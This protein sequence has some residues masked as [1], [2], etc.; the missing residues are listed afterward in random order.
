MFGLY[1]RYKL[2]YTARSARKFWEE[3][4]DSPFFIEKYG[5]GEEE[6]TRRIDRRR[7]GR[8]GKKRVWLQ[9]LRDGSLDG[10]NFQMHFAPLRNGRPPKADETDDSTLHTIF[11]RSGDPVKIATDSLPID[12]C[13]NQ[14]L[15]MRIPPTL[16][17]KDIEKELGQCAG[18]QYL[19]VGEAHANKHYFAI[20]WAVFDTP[21]NTNDAKS[22]MLDSRVIQDN[23]LQLDV[24][25]RGAQVKFRTAPSGSGKI[26]RLARDYKQARD[27]VRFVEREDRE[28]LW[29]DGSAQE[30]AD[31]DALDTN[32]SA[33]IS[34]RVI[35]VMDLRPHFAPGEDEDEVLLQIADSAR[36]FSSYDEEEDVRRSIEKGLD[37]HLDLL[38]QVYNC[39][40]YSSTM[41]DFPEEL[42]RRARGHFRRCY[43]NGETEAEREGRDSGE[44][45]QNMGEEQWAENLD[46]KH[47]LLVGASSVDIE[48][49]GGVDIDKLCLELAIPFTRQD[50]KEKHRCI[51]EVPNVAA[52]GEAVDAATPPTKP[53]DKLFRALIFVQKHVCNKHKDLIERELG[54]ERRA[55][56]AYLNNYI[57]DPTR[58]MPPLTG[59]LGGGRGGAGAG[60]NGHAG[61]VAAVP[62]AF[63]GGDSTSFGGVLRLGA[64]TFAP[65]GAYEGGGGGRRRGGRRGGGGG[66]GDGYRSPSPSRNGGGRLSERLGG[67]TNNPP[68]IH[69]GA[70]LS[71]AGGASAASGGIAGPPLHLRLGGQNPYGLPSP[72]VRGGAGMTSPP[73][74]SMATSSLAA[75]DPLPP[76]PRPLD[77]RAARGQ[78]RSYQDLDTGG[79][80]GQ[81]DVMDLEY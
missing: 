65:E 31:R 56:I 7:R 70:V 13:P 68:P 76:A 17:R 63:G 59:S 48:E 53:C 81:Q 79:G 39:D 72:P 55:D 28:L 25:S 75:A 14:L 51:V 54:T 74:P 44:E 15:I 43:P 26:R 57:R 29:P 52:A 71:G 20:A 32:A 19:A 64:S 22:K 38:R 46:R 27:V 73:P 18:F 40:Y 67:A 1:K 9:E 24:A 4:R 8:E 33:E 58:V 30:P 23:S 36:D 62:L 37:L 16:A 34:R 11:S 66:G 61:G 50:D 60:A 49:Q 2:V 21:E 45:G 78:Q 69:F 42:E 41:C 12:P 80:D 35:E 6:V 10:V 5:M 3:K 77:P 47:A